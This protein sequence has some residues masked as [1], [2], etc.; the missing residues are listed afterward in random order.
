MVLRCV[1]SKMLSSV[2]MKQRGHSFM[3]G[4]TQAFW[5]VRSCAL[6]ASN[7]GCY[8]LEVASKLYEDC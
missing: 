5:W 2:T 3:I 8:S 1:G 6:L 7:V 4:K